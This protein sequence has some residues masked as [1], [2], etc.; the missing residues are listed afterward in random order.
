[1]DAGGP[2]PN[3]TKGLAGGLQSVVE[4]LGPQADIAAM[5]EEARKSRKFFF[6]RRLLRCCRFYGSNAAIAPLMIATPGSVKV[7]L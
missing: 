7:S 5:V 2:A 1:M 6:K 4:I 3:L